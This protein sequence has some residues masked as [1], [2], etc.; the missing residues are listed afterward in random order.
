MLLT[1]PDGLRAD[2]FPPVA[3]PADVSYGRQPD[4]GPGGF[5]FSQPTPGA[6][7]VTAGVT[8]VLPAPQFSHLPG[9][10]TNSFELTLSVTNAGAVIRYTLDGSEPTEDSPVYA[11]P[12][13][14]TNRTAAPNDF[15]LIPTAPSG[16]QPPAGQAFKGS[17]VRAK[18]FKTAALPGA[19][20][21]LTFFVDSRGP[22]RYTVPVVSLTTDPANFFDPETGI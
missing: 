5:F 15:S 9:F 4:G 22:A 17:V 3:L 11:A 13:L 16:W 6:A 14:I 7:N 12:L 20:A 21:T 1:R 8:E 19:T 2:E 10:Y 18:A